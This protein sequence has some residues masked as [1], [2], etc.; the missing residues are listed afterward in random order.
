MFQF[1]VSINNWLTIGFSS[2]WMPFDQTTS[3]SPL[4]RVKYSRLPQ[5]KPLVYSKRI[6]MP[7]LPVRMFDVRR[8]PNQHVRLALIILFHGHLDD[9]KTSLRIDVPLR[10]Y[11][12]CPL[13]SV[14]NASY[15]TYLMGT[16][17]GSIWS[18]VSWL[19]RPNNARY[20]MHLILIIIRTSVKKYR[21]IKS[22]FQ[23]F[24]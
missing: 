23:I 21:G 10:K 2:P 24:W 19:R 6:A 17:P 4:R 14:F 11:I 12:L 7:W 16:V 9:Y 8:A 15:C 18:D 20:M 22:S 1:I 13:V 5:L 3:E